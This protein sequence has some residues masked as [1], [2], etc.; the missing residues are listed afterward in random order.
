MDLE[1]AEL[2][3]ERLKLKQQLGERQDDT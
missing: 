3:L 1:K 2:E